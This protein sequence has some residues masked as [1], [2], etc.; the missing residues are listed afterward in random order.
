M[1][2]HLRFKR[3]LLFLQEGERIR[4]VR[5]L[6]DGASLPAGHAFQLLLGVLSGTPQVEW[7]RT[8]LA[9]RLDVPLALVDALFGRLEDLNLVEY[10]DPEIVGNDRYDRQL[11][12]FDALAPVS[13]HH[14]SLARQ[15]RLNNAQV[16]ILGL[17]GIG[18]QIAQSL[19]AAGIGTLVLV[20]GDIVEASN[21][22]RQIL[23]C[24]DDIGTP[25]V[26]AA[27]AGIL[28]IAPNCNV[29]AQE[30]S[31]NSVAEWNDLMAACPSVRHIVLSADKPVHLVNWVSEARIAFNYHFIKCGYMSTQGL[32]GP[33]LGPD[34]RSYDALFSSWAP[35]IDA[36]PECIATF[37]ARSIA[38]TMAASN[39]IMA[40]IAALELIKHITGA[41]SLNLREQRLLLDLNDYST[42]IG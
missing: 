12:F 16:L 4:V 32:I 6:N 3:H 15:Q 38:P 40:N 30:R 20:D 33:L 17:G 5:D 37:N 29:M 9:Q 36:Q 34:T 31:I 27:R 24:P 23:F 10:F 26:H 13:D 41:G 19:A 2:R 22:N 18:H 28:R 7:A 11:L 35:L 14:D 21:L 1:P 25:K 8:E 39:A 42:K